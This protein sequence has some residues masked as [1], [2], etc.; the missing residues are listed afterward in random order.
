M[1]MVS[2]SFAFSPPS[3]YEF[4]GATYYSPVFMSS[5]VLPNPFGGASEGFCTTSG[6]Y[7]D[8]SLK[9]I[10]N[11]SLVHNSD[12]SISDTIYYYSYSP[13][14]PIT[15]DCSQ[16]PH[17]SLDSSTN[18]CVCDSGY[19]A[20]SESNSCVQDCSKNP[21]VNVPI[22][23]H[24]FFDKSETDCT[25]YINS[26]YYKTGSFNTTSSGECTYNIC[27]VNDYSP[28]PCTPKGWS[29]IQPS[30]YIFK[31]K[32]TSDAQ[33]S[34][35]V[36]GVN[37]YNYKVLDATPDC[38]SEKIL[39]C[40]LKPNLDNN[41]TGIPPPDSNNTNPDG[42]V[43]NSPDLNGSTINSNNND[44]NST[45][46]SNALLGQLSDDLK[47]FMKQLSSSDSNR[48]KNDN[49]NTNK[50][51]EAI[52]DNKPDLNGIE[53]RLDKLIG[54]G[55]AEN[56]D[57]SALIPN[58]FNDTLP[59]VR[60]VNYSAPEVNSTTI[61][62]DNVT[63]S[64]KD[65]SSKAISALTDLFGSV[66]F[67][68]LN[69]FDIGKYDFEDIYIDITIFNYPLSGLLISANLLNGFNWNFIRLFVI[70]ASLIA[71][72]HYSIDRL[73]K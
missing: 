5:A 57:L 41:D 68:I 38:T 4:Q 46:K 45:N 16:Y 32:V 51:I 60:D 22:G 3:T 35:Y 27:L 8:G 33:C 69:M 31:G 62:Y 43:N 34:Q 52:K 56:L 54:S 20:G 39:Y 6:K 49:A 12:G 15:I 53:S 71:S 72:I 7:A 23:W 37:Y 17:M 66:D 2:V 29:N 28:D 48:T 61:L 14:P 25:S 9:L 55:D 59:L 11:V 30:G 44:S 67:G 19:V 47:D 50:L 73:F 13:T 18:Q 40:Y 70:L 26:T 42:T 21:D 63:E 58:D 36:D 10:C 64:F 65:F 24:V 1:M